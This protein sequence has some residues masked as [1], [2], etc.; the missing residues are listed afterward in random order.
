LQL[1]RIYSRDC[2]WSYVRS[3][4]LLGKSAHYYYS[5]LLVYAAPVCVDA[6]VLA[7]IILVIV[8]LLCLLSALFYVRC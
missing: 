5:Y 2:V 4:G 1:S 3:T 6:K 8:L 7:Y